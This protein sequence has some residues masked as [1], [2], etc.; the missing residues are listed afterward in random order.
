MTKAEEEKEEKGKGGRR[1]GESEGG[2]KIER[3][4]EKEGRKEEKKLAKGR[5]ITYG[6]IKKKLASVYHSARSSD[7]I[8]HHHFTKE[9]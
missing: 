2:R 6:K 4:L 7:R 9:V 1:E 8:H 5:R 3:K